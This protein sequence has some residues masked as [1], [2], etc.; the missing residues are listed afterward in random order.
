MVAM[1]QHSPLPWLDLPIS[2]RVKDPATLVRFTTRQIGRV[3]EA[4]RR[5]AWLGE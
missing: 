1:D 2:V 5:A 4:Y 3:D